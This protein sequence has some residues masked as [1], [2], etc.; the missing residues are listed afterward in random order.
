MKGSRSIHVDLLDLASKTVISAQADNM[1][2]ISVTLSAPYSAFDKLKRDVFRAIQRL[3]HGLEASEELVQR[4]MQLHRMEAKD[5][6]CPQ[7]T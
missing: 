1:A 3:A 7:E 6:G 4:Q 2:F 5:D